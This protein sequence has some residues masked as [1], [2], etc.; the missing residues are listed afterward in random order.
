VGWGPFL[1]VH[2]LT[3][4]MAASF[5]V[6]LFYVQHQFEDTHWSRQGRW[7]RDEAAL[8]GSS[9]YDLPAPLAWL[10]A[11]IGVHHVHH[12]DSKVPFY[13][14]PEV[15]RE[16]PELKQIGRMTLMESFRCVKLRLWDE[17]RGKMVSFEDARVARNSPRRR[18]STAP[19][20]ESR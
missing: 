9:Y 6:W 2:L 15:L 5:G 3:V 7:Q 10:T 1:L 18:G 12:V 14:L 8:H 16:R 11:N 13:R 20:R 4:G 19:R 17:Q